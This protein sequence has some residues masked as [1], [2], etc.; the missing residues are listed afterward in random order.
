MDP[1]PASIHPYPTAIIVNTNQGVNKGSRCASIDNNRGQG[2]TTI[3][4]SITQHGV[5]PRLG[6]IKPNDSCTE[7]NTSSSGA[8]VMDL[9]GFV[10]RLYLVRDFAG[11]TFR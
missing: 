9:P 1:V 7:W 11:K 5:Q 10:P 4:P 8:S 2:V 6:L 3:C